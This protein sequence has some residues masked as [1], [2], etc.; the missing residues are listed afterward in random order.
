MPF[1]NQCGM[2]TRAVCASFRLQFLIVANRPMNIA[3]GIVTPWM[4]MSLYI[5]PRIHNAT[6]ADVTASVSAS[7]VASLW[8]ASMWS[9]A[10]VIRREKWMGTLGSTLS[11]HLNPFSAVLSKIA[12][13]VAYDALL[14]SLSVSAFCIAFQLPIQLEHPML[15]LMAFVL[16]VLFGVSSSSLLA[17][18]LILSRNPFHIT[19]IFGTPIL[20]LGGL[21]IP[22]QY[23][24]SFCSWIAQGINFYWLREFMN[25]L[26][27]VYPDYP[28]LWIGIGL[29]AIYLVLAYI[30]MQRLLKRAKKEAT[31][32]LS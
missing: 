13:A 4:F 18:V 8:S 19:N 32:E 28:P 16:V 17:G 15:T 20:L 6:A 14:I 25:S 10:G 3:T 12:G 5:L 23:L 11:G 30:A 31:F 7:I 22:P 29:S 24:P 26:P 21:L 1:R 2:R 9:G 27:H